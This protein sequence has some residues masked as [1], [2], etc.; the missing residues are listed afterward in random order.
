MNLLCEMRRELQGHEELFSSIQLEILQGKFSRLILDK[1]TFPHVFERP[2]QP[3]SVFSGS[4]QLA[5]VG[6]FL[7]CELAVHFQLQSLNI[8]E[9]HYG[10]LPS[11]EPHPFSRWGMKFHECIHVQKVLQ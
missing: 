6:G 9:D 7:C 1:I 5:H 8:L 11:L 3:F 10:S 4:V 2:E